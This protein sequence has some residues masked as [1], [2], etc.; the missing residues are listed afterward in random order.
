MA[1]KKFPIISKDII[2]RHGLAIRDSEFA[3]IL[4]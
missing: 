2:R 4:S 1:E 3:V